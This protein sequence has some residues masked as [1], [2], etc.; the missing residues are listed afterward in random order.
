[1]SISSSTYS[2]DSVLTGLMELGIS[3]GNPTGLG[4]RQGLPGPRGN[5]AARLS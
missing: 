5:Q 2:L 4:G 1:M 3:Q